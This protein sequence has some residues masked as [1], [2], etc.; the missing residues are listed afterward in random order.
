MSIHQQLNA[1]N[2]TNWRMAHEHSTKPNKEVHLNPSCKYIRL[3]NRVIDEEGLRHCVLLRH[4]KCFRRVDKSMLMDNKTLYC[5]EFGD[6]VEI[7][8][9][10]DDI[11]PNCEYSIVENEN[12]RGQKIYELTKSCSCPR[13]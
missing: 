3:M 13:K 11:P 5:S 8:F 2:M 7:H 4:C 6:G 9:Y 10:I 1:P 12:E